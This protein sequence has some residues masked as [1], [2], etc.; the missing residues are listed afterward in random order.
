MAQEK[1]RLGIVGL[2]RFVEIAHL[3]AY[4]ESAYR[5]LVEVAAICDLDP[6]RVAAVGDAY[7]IPGRFTDHRAMLAGTEL[8]A[9]AVVTPD[10]AHTQIV[11]DAIAAG[12]HVLVEKPLTMKAGEAARI[13]AAARDAGVAVI[14]DF[15]K[16]EDPCHAEARDRIARGEYGSL[17]FGWAWM[18]DVLSVA[19][20]GFFKS[21]LAAR[22]SPNWF[23]GVHFYDL[24]CFLAGLEP[25]E[26]RAV[27]YRQ[28]L[29]ARG[30]ATYD[31]IKADFLFETGA[32]VSVFTSWNLPD[33][34]PLLTRQGL[35]LQFS[36][37]DV[38][39][40]S[41]RR[42]FVATS[43]SGY[44]L[45]NP[46]FLRNTPRGRAGY[47]IESIGEA[48]RLF[49][50]LERGGAE[51]REEAIAAS[52]LATARDGLRATLMG[53]GVD[54]SL[55]GGRTEDGVVVGVPVDLRELRRE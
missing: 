22:S 49:L 40:D 20:G 2:G 4:F 21:D 15:H 39:I 8:D 44:R 3:P 12:T 33:T 43:A 16:R 23:L 5:E 31:A 13:V 45:V 50:A 26:V 30:I 17:Q 28:V 53:E 52:G 55:A 10:H 6:A 11:L 48:M 47:G 38:E 27:G 35:Y 37:G 42:G 36:A 18:Q 54:R 19:A 41:A 9:V 46:M 51:P 34:A 32:A 1:L 25:R 14:V 24:V 7:R 29:A